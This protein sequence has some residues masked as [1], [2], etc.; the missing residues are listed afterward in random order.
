MTESFYSVRD[1][2]NSLTSLLKSIGPHISSALVGI[3]IDIWEYP[4]TVICQSLETNSQNPT[5]QV[6]WTC[7]QPLGLFFRFVIGVYL[8]SSSSVKKN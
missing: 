3:V 4:N 6:T 2:Y 7:S 1:E 8:N 5:D